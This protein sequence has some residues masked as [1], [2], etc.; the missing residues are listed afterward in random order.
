MFVD[1]RQK[2]RRCLAGHAL[3]FFVQ[4]FPIDQPNQ[5]LKVFFFVNFV[6][7]ALPSHISG[8]TERVNNVLLVQFE[9]EHGQEHPQDLL[10]VAR[11]AL[12]HEARERAVAFYF[13]LH[14]AD[15]DQ[16]LPRGAQ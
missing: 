16:C 5:F 10:D 6:F 1:T 13:L 11:G 3:S 14:V 15:R 7:T 8:L 4:K 2:V 12:Q 9:I